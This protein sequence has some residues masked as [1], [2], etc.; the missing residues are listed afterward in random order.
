MTAMG[1][2]DLKDVPKLFSDC[3]FLTRKIGLA[4]R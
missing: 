2:V 3:D 4:E 1:N